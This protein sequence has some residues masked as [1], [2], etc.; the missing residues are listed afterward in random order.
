WGAGSQQSR[1][2]ATLQHDPNIS[3][4]YLG[5][6][7]LAQVAGA[8]QASDILVVPS[9][10]DWNEQFGRVAVEAMAC[11]CAVVATTSGALGE[12]VAEGG[13][14]VE[15]NAPRQLASVIRA[16]ALSRD[17]RLSLGRRGRD[18]VTEGLTPAA[19]A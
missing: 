1:V 6:L 4:R 8:L 12:V 19:V 11:A 15:P 17:L 16:L 18:R 2:A 3:G 14:L 5:V 7:D 9:R 13:V 10:V